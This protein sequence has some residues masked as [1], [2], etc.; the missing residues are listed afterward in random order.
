M[1]VKEDFLGGVAHA[2]GRAIE[3]VH[4]FWVSAPWM[5]GVSSSL[6]DDT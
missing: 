4:V 6:I 2:L 3:L 1:Y 5:L